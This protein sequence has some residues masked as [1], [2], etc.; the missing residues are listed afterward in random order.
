MKLPVRFLPLLPAL[1]LVACSGTGD[2]P[3]GTVVPSPDPVAA[4]RMKTGDGGDDDFHKMAAKYGDLNPNMATDP[5]AKNGGKKEFAGFQRDNPEFKGRWD[6]KEYKGGEKKK[7]FWGDKDYVKK[8]YEGNTDASALKKDSRFGRQKSRE[9][10]LVARDAGKA[11]KTDGY[12]TNR[13][14]EEGRDG[15]PKYSDAET[16][17]RRRVFT[18]PDTRGMTVDDTNRMM[19]R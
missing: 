6:K 19:G 5:N 12:A 10:D 16:D 8:V 2:G 11:Y 17:Q 14:R 15:L 3:S 7:S 9:G 13:A 1:C 4:G 18:P